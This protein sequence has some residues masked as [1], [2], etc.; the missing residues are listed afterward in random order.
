[1][2]FPKGD[3]TPEAFAK[4]F[5]GMSYL[6]LLVQPSENFKQLIGNVTFEP[7]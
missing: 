3:K 5:I 7:G 4:Y 2:I 1:V 6:N